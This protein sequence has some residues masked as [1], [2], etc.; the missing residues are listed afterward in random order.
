MQHSGL[1]TRLA[2]QL[3]AILLAKIAGLGASND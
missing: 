1:W 3:E 2:E